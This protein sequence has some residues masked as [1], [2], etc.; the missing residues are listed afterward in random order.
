MLKKVN[1]KFPAEEKL[2][3]GGPPNKASMGCF[4]SDATTLEIS[5]RFFFEDILCIFTVAFE[6]LVSISEK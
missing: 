1:Y 3:Q 2:V 4:N 6:A 5:P